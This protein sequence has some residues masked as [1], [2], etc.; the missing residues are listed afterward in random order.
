MAHRP[1]PT[2]K[3]LLI[4]FI[5]PAYD[6]E[7]V[8]GGTLEA[9]H[10]AGKALH[11]P[12]ELIVADDASTDDTA[13]VAEGHGA[14]VVRVAHRQIAATRNSGAQAASGEMFIFVDADTLV[15]ETVVRAA[16]DAVR[17]RA[18][19]GGAT[20]QFDRDVP[21]YAKVLMPVLA[22]LYRAAGLAPG[23]F[24]FCTR[25]AFAAVGGV[26]EAF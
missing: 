19:G 21:R 10:A 3:K 13:A 18:V 24:L 15:N 17:D 4:S 22:W 1:Q 5:V 8:L 26:D 16:V 20:V 9:L 25:G 11:E 6:E 12:Y 7:N 14:R 2:L 23:C